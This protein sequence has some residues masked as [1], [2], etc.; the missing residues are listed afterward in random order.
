MTLVFIPFFVDAWSSLFSI[1]YVFQVWQR[2][3]WHPL[4][5]FGYLLAF[6]LSSFLGS[7][8]LWRLRRLPRVGPTGWQIVC[9]TVFPFGAVLAA[10][11]NH[12]SSWAT[13]ML[14]AGLFR[15]ETPATL[16]LFAQLDVSDPIFRQL[17]QW[18]EFGS[19]L[20]VLAASCSLTFMFEYGQDALAIFSI[21]QTCCCVFPILALLKCQS[22]KALQEA[23]QRWT[24]VS[25]LDSLSRE[26]RPVDRMVDA[27]MWWSAVTSAVN[28]GLLGYLLTVLML[29]T[30]QSRIAVPVVVLA[31]SLL[32]WAG[33]LAGVRE[34]TIKERSPMWESFVAFVV[35]SLSAIIA[36]LGLSMLYQ[37]P[38]Y[39]MAIP[40]AFV[41]A[42]FCVLHS[43]PLVLLHQTVHQAKE[44]QTVYADRYLGCVYLGRLL[45]ISVAWLQYVYLDASPYLLS[46]IAIW[47][48][49]NHL[50]EALV[51]WKATWFNKNQ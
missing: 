8:V 48:A 39:Y 14:L 2:E 25:Q 43:S 32:N 36:S 16:S 6:H 45:G 15:P 12:S 51:E 40:H 3:K 1:G 27:T 34:T 31:V 13:Y 33:S 22:P 17:V 24:H 10:M 7:S 30:S 44:E 20:G 28:Y 9:Y 4:A 29:Q 46:A 11:A 41:S 26:D 42:A 49:R 50:I 19:L 21:C 23:E 5:F 37:G 35:L 38:S 47:V 18:R